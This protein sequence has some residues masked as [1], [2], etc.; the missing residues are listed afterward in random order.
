MPANEFPIKITGDA[1]ELTKATDDAKDQLEQAGKSVEILGD[2]I[3]VKV[4]D[5]IKEMLASS[6]LI[7]PALS[8]A[9]APLTAITFGIELFEKLSDKIKEVTNDM[10]GWDSSAQ[11][12]Y[13]DLVK[14]NEAML[15]FN[16]GLEIQKLHLNEIGKTGT[17]KLSQ[18]IE[19]NAASIKIWNKELGETQERLNYLNGTRKVEFINPETGQSF[20]EDIKNKA[21]ATE[22]ELA[23]WDKDI[24]KAQ[25]SV[26]ELNEKIKQAQEVAAPGLVKQKTIEEQQEKISAGEQVLAAKKQQ[27]QAERQLAIDTAHSQLE[28]GKI[29]AAQEEDIVRSTYAKERDATIQYLRQREALL[30]SD[31]TKTDTEKKAIIDSTAAEIHAAQAKYRDEA[32]KLAGA[33]AAKQRAL[34]RQGLEDS[35]A[36][37]QED[38]KVIEATLANELAHHK[39]TKQQEIAASADAKQKELQQ[40]ISYQQQIQALYEKGSKEWQAV[41]VK[42]TKILDEQK[43]IR[44][45]AEA[46]EAKAA[47]AERQAEA[48][49][50]ETAIAAAHD[51]ERVTEA[52]LANE[53]AHHKIT[54]QQEIQAIADAKQKE[55]QIE[56]DYLKQT[57]ALYDQDSK[58]WDAAQRKITKIL[59]DQKV[60]RQNAQ[61]D[62]AKNAEQQWQKVV[63]GMQS[64]FSS[65]TQGII[66][67]HQTISQSWTKMVDGITTKFIESLQRQLVEM[68]AQAATKEGVDKAY[69]AKSSLSASYDTAHKAFDWATQYVGPVLAAP[70]AAAAFVTAESLGSAEGGQY[71]VPNNQLTM[72]HPQE[73]VLPA[74]IA[75]QMRN[76]IGGGGNSGGGGTTVIVNH[77]V[78]AVDAA[79]FQQHIRRHSNMIANE[80]T[81]ALKRKA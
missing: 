30:L 41:Q 14:N 40:E 9:F 80:V 27:A 17:D 49:K 56:I 75:N 38:E 67:G 15:K 43:T 52:T 3:G 79:S 13:A 81:R 8:E 33:D 2:L 47:E 60:I 4:P 11:A 23:N 26:T 16:Q 55:L 70:I 36:I 1:S 57:Q 61:A 59:A 62:E 45:K 35:I 72:L 53:L 77:S 12:M 42:I 78:N 29:T 73:M 25:A 22:D 5:S 63:S 31:T 74:G 19:N 51:E 44:Q 24:K 28:Q 66:S 39:I 65:F 7:G 20:F 34:K 76:V 18:Q 48:R 10:A 46:D 6:E 71:Y 50:Y 64:T 37:A 54:K 69:Y 32:I 58:E 68:I 21:F